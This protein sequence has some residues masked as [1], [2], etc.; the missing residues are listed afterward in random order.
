MR[1]TVALLAAVL[2]LGACAPEP[3][4][5]LIRAAHPSALAGSS[6]QL[7]AV[8]G[9]PVAATSPLLLG[10]DAGN[11]SGSGPCNAFGGAYRYDAASGVLH[12]DGLISTQRACADLAGNQLEAAYVAGLRG[13]A[14]ASLDTEGR[15][16]L[17][18]TGRDLRFTV[19]G[20]PAPIESPAGPS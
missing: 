3:A 19:A 5:S 8:A 14:A 13:V 1:G 15:L 4:P 7:Q 16:V 6:W 18:G 17:T 10:F 20:Q 9:V 11:V 12:L 2:V